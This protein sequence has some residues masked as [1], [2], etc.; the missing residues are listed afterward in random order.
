M[1][2]ALQTTDENNYNSDDSGSEFSGFEPEDIRSDIETES[3][4]SE[5]D[6]DDEPLTE[7]NSRFSPLAVCTC[8][9]N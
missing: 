8:T 2:D 7:W 9:R 5:W 6:S 4:E 1:E 3:S